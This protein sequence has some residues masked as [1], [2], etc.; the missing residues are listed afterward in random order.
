[1]ASIEELLWDD[2]NVGHIAR[3]RVATSE[4]EEVVFD[5]E[6]LFFDAGHTDR[7]GRL[8]VL[9]VTPSKRYLAVYLD[10]PAGSRSYPV[11]ARSMTAKERRIFRQS[12]EDD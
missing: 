7:P 4:V 5:P 10:T 1:M 11:T 3:H 2:Q 6:S 9:G 8:V 12:R